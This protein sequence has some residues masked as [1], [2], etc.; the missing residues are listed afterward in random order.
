MSTLKTYIIDSSLAGKRLDHAIISL[1]EESIS[2]SRAQ[3]L[4]KSGHI[5]VN[6]TAQKRAYAVEEADAIQITLPDATPM[7]LSA[8]HI[9]LE[10]V[11]E[12]EALLVI[13]KQAGLT[14]HPG[15]GQRDG[16]LV[17]ALLHHCGESLSGIGGVER[18]GIV[19]RLDK[20]T[21]GLMVIAKTDNA[22]THL[23]NQ[24]QER[25]IERRYLAFCWGTPPV[26]AGTI[27]TELGR[28][29][30]DHR[31]RAVVPNKGKHA[32]T[33]FHV[34]EAFGTRTASL[35]ECRLDTGRTH[36]I[37]VHLAHKRCPLIG[38]TL[39]GGTR[40]HPNITPFPRQALHAYKLSF[41]HPLTH[42]I[43]EFTRDFRQC[44]ENTT[45]NDENS[46]GSDLI[47]LYNQLKMLEK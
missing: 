23:A 16:T 42:H 35:I 6:Q 40:N 3:Q 15:A 29:P 4:I 17:N 31:K 24:L 37:R 25:Q 45:H 39:Y 7:H 14:V 19:H 21:T 32:V 33:H 43:V 2:R 41:T 46:A 38:D 13:N 9:P 27:E 5:L 22:H 18:P 34:L 28:H 11:Y 20:D 44:E 30:K 12:D 26:L 8:E 10:V 36:Q 47:A 1:L